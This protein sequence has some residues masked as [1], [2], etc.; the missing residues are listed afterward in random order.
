LKSVYE[1]RAIAFIDILGFSA[2]IQRDEIY[3]VRNG[4]KLIGTHVARLEA[5]PQTPIVTST[6]SD[7][8]VLSAR[9][10]AEGLPYLVHATAA[11]VAELLL[12]GIL[13]RGAVTTGKL[14]HKKDMIFGHAL[15]HAYRM[16]Q[17][18]AVYPRI[19]IDFPTMDNF[20]H[21]RNQQLNHRQQ[22]GASAYFRRDFDNQYPLDIFSPFLFV[23]K[24]KW[25]YRA[26]G[27]QKDKQTYRCRN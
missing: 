7:T 8:I 27:C 25:H 10:D 17:E 15:I 16:E 9:N 5:L 13:C 3:K 24:K 4:L 11:L 1:D 12:R 23:P 14:Y 6:F 2:L 26:E 20:V 22:T 18:L 21:F 19:I